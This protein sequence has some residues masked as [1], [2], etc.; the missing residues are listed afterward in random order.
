MP[1]RSRCCGR[2]EARPH[3]AQRLKGRG[4]AGV[5]VVTW[6]AKPVALTKLQTDVLVTRDADLAEAA[7]SLV[8]TCGVEH[9]A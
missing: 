5:G 1:A 9:V 6:A 8:F 3:Q 2:R 4:A 7:A